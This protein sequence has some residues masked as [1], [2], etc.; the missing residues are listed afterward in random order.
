MRAWFYVESAILSLDYI[1]NALKTMPE[2]TY[3][4]GTP[5]NRASK[6][7]HS[8]NK[9]RLNI[10]ETSDYRLFDSLL[11]DFLLG[12]NVDFSLLDGT[13]KY[14]DV[15]IDDPSQ[16]SDFFISSET[17]L[18]MSKLDVQLQIDIERQ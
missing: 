12:S 7:V 17:L 14:I 5:I 9:V 10:V 6:K 4:M 13:L 18:M 2:R 1:C 15:Y 16:D 11:S 3:Q 8:C